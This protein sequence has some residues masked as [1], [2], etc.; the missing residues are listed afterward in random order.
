MGR[1]SIRE[2]AGLGY[3]HTCGIVPDPRLSGKAWSR[4]QAG[5][6]YEESCTAKVL[7]AQPQKAAHHRFTSGNYPATWTKFCQTPPQSHFGCAKIALLV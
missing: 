2:E 1:G 5:H 4:A 3:H 6:K 7:A